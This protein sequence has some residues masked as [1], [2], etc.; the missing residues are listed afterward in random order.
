[1]FQVKT[2][3][4]FEHLINL[5]SK[6]VFFILTQCTKLRELNSALVVVLKHHTTRFCTSNYFI[7]LKIGPCNTSN[8]YVCNMWHKIIIR[9]CTESNREVTVKM[10]GSGGRTNFHVGDE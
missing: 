1:M 10:P 8:K 9:T 5:K 3:L 7:I 4:E 2:T 6:F